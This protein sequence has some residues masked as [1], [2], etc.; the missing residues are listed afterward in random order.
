MKQQVDRAARYRKRAGD[1]RSK[2][3]GMNDRYWRTAMIEAAE[4]WERLAD[5]EEVPDASPAGRPP[6]RQSD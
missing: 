3:D 4:T 6:P 5:K 1:A 2:A